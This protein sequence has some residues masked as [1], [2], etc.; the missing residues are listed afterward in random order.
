MVQALRVWDS[1][2]LVLVMNDSAALTIPTIPTIQQARQKADV[3]NVNGFTI[4]AEG[5]LFTRSTIERDTRQSN[6]M[7][8]FQDEGGVAK[9]TSQNRTV[10]PE[11]F[12]IEGVSH[13]PSSSYGSDSIPVA[14]SHSPSSHSLPQLHANILTSNSEIPQPSN[15]TSKRHSTT[16]LS[17]ENLHIQRTYQRISNIGGI[18]RDGFVDGMELTRERKSEASINGYLSQKMQQTNGVNRRNSGRAFSN[19]IVAETVS[20]PLSRSAPASQ[21]TNYT[22]GIPSQPENTVSGALVPRHEQG[23]TLRTHSAAVSVPLEADEEEIADLKVLERV[24]RYG[25][26]APTYGKHARLVL[27][28]RKAFMGYPAKNLKIQGIS[29]KKTKKKKEAI[30][31]ISSGEIAS[32]YLV[33][34]SRGSVGTSNSSR[35][36]SRRPQ[37]IDSLASSTSSHSMNDQGDF[38]ATSTPLSARQKEASRIDKWYTEMLIPSSRDDGGNIA[39]WKLASESEEKLRRRVMKGIP[40]RW[41]AAAWEALMT[42]AQLKSI[43]KGKGKGR[44]EDLKSSKRFYVSLKYT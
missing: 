35:R 19:L 43:G 4:R 21:Y 16:S 6:E 11:E 26:F 44:I 41:R 17:A 1:I 9:P 24:D 23:Q 14:Y 31:D 7:T 5:D 42:R 15:A 8:D 28:S 25:F 36:S 2:F 29:G 40:D 22:N 32:P 38:S 10:A 18:P 37:N 27:L 12:V 3:S 20:S 33:I 39:T 34:D 13:G 30:S